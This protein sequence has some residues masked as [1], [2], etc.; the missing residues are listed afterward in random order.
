MGVSQAG[1]GYDT[2]HQS[3]SEEIEA[4]ALLTRD[5]RPDPDLC[6]LLWERVV[7]LVTLGFCHY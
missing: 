2:Q 4:V 1:S 6:R 3:V 5:L 7:A